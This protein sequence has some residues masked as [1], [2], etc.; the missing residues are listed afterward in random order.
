MKH[1]PSAILVALFGFTA[2][3]PQG[4]TPAPAAPA[5]TAVATSDVRPAASQDAGTAARNDIRIL[6][7]RAQSRPASQP[8]DPRMREIEAQILDAF[9]TVR[10][11]TA[12]V[13]TE[14]F[15][16]SFG[17]TLNSHSQGTVQYLR[18]GAQAMFMQTAMIRS[19]VTTNEAKSLTQFISETTDGVTWSRLI[20]DGPEK[21][22]IKAPYDP[23][24]FVLMGKPLFDQLHKLCYLGYA[25]EDVV[26]GTPVHVIQAELSDTAG[27]Y[28]IALTRYFFRKA[29]G[30]LM[31]SIGTGAREQRQV[32][33]YRNVQ[34]NGK[35]EHGSFE[36]KAPPGAVIKDYTTSGAQ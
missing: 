23:S 30:I 1:L 19:N 25:G 35:V 8:L 11:Y 33:V 27:G 4:Q 7:G 22:H 31:G 20:D 32:T 6:G 36:L 12:E 24:R 26:D 29:D 34:V 17:S 5:A 9:A 2:C 28:P 15:L 13:S 10:C 21:T 3:A 18:D 14:V 16:N